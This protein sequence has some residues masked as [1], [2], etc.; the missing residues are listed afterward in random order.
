MSDAAFTLSTAPIW[1]VQTVVYNHRGAHLYM[2]LTTL[3]ELRPFLRELHIDDV[4][5]TRLG[6][7]GDRDGA[8][9]GLVIENDRFVVLGVLLRCRHVT[10]RV[11][12]WERRRDTH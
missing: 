6:V 9:L 5:Q 7:V 2:S 11:P 12:S 1:S 4:T 10:G 8:D 3:V